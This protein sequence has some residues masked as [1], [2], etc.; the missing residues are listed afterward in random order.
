MSP[1]QR[2]LPRPSR[3]WYGWSFRASVGLPILQWD[4][5]RN[6][7]LVHHRTMFSKVRL[8]PWFPMPMPRM[9]QLRH[10]GCDGYGGEPGSHTGQPLKPSRGLGERRVV[11][12]GLWISGP[13][14][15][16]RNSGVVVPVGWRFVGKDAALCIASLQSDGYREPRMVNDAIHQRMV[17]SHSSQIASPSWRARAL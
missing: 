17:K 13:T 1:L 14:V 12:E 15:N 6:P 9:G 7:F 10:S 11:V 4:R 5:V 8:V 2:S 3:T 16:G